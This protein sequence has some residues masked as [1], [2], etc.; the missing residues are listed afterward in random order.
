M[1]AEAPNPHFPE[2]PQIAIGAVVVDDSVPGERRIVLVRRARPPMAGRWSLPGGRLEFGERIE[3]GVR[4]EVFEESGLEVN[5]GPLIE[6]VE[7]ID[8][9]YHYV[10]L[11]YVC[12]RTGGELRAGDDAS[13]VVSVRPD[14]C[15]RY[16]V[17]EAVLRVVAK[18]LTL[19]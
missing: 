9:P 15:A 8:P 19:C 11:D 1:T 14:E 16:G 4:R 6:V 10:I 5:V 13:D 7:V 17:T 2:V 12:R 3:V 18:A